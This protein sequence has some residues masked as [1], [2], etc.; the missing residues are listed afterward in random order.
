VDEKLKVRMKAHIKQ[1][2]PKH[3][4]SLDERELTPEAGNT[5]K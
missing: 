4:R 3:W 1:E 5:R 2:K